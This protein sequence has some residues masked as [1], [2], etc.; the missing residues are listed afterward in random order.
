MFYKCFMNLKLGL[1]VL[2]ESCYIFFM[3]EG[4]VFYETNRISSCYT[5]VTH[6][7]HQYMG[8][9]MR[10]PTMWYVRPAKAQTN[11]CVCAV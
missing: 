9:K 1:Q 8:C 2:L 4:A 7:L 11:L 6:F 10:F 5:A 3:K